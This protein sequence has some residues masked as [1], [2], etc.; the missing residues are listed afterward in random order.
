M[1]PTTRSRAV[2]ATPIVFRDCLI[3]CLPLVVAVVAT[4]SPKT[5]RIRP[6]GRAPHAV[7]S[8]SVSPLAPC[9]PP[10]ADI[11]ARTA[12]VFLARRS[13][14]PCSASVVQRGASGGT[15][16]SGTLFTASAERA[17][18]RDRRVTLRDRAARPCDIE[19]SSGNAELRVRAR[20]VHTQESSRRL[21]H[22][23]G[24]GVAAWGPVRAAT[25]L[26]HP[27]A[28]TKRV[29]AR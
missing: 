17:S 3:S 12:T 7:M 25:A 13:V 29:M 8:G 28:R 23:H 5:G 27:L 9:E 24:C 10:R 6:F 11:S 4:T 14:R 18:V 2:R 22:V 20:S 21:G 16:A 26:D 1:S 15:L 19:C